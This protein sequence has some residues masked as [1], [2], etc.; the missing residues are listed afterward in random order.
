MKR[1]WKYILIIFAVFLLL[2]SFLFDGKISSFLNQI[3]IPLINNLMFGIFL[4]GSEVF[5]L[6]LL[7]FMFIWKTDMRKSLL[8]LLFSVGVAGSIGFFIKII[9]QRLRPF[10]QGLISLIPLVSNGTYI[11]WNFSF[12]SFSALLIFSAFPEISKKLPS[13]RPYWIIL[14]SLILLSQLY[15]GIHF[16]SDILFGSV[17]GYVIGKFVSEKGSKILW[18]IFIRKK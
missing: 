5:L 12:P 9:F 18:E 7:V 2:L 16:L 3:H 15:L 8:P 13:F 1:G 10:Q 6:I 14:G 17:L 11:T 4:M